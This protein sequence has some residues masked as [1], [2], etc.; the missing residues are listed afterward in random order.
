MN[1]KNNI[2]KPD[3]VI[4]AGGK[5]SRI[6]KYTNYKQKCSAIIN[7]KPF[8]NYLINHVSKYEINR[9]FILVGYKPDKIIRNY[10]NK[11]KNFRKIKCITEKKPLGTG[12]ALYQLKKYKIN[13]FYLLNGDTIL[14]IDLSKLSKKISKNS[15][16][17]MSIIKNYNYKSNKQL[18]K[19]NIK[20]RKVIYSKNQNLMNGGVYYFKKKF[21][22][23]IQNKKIS[24][25]KEILPNLIKK[26][27]IDGKIFKE[28]FFIDIGTPGSFAEAEKKINKFIKKPAVF[29]DRDGVINYDYGYVSKFKDFKIKPGVIKSLKLLIKKKY[30][31]FIITNQA[32]IA[33]NKFSLSDFEK[34]NLQFKEYLSKKKV[35]I[36]DIKFCPHH[37]SG[38]IKKYKKKCKCR[39]PSN[40]MITDTIKEWDIDLNKSLMIGDKI[41]DELC[42]KKS[43]IKFYY[44]KK[45]LLS[46]IKNVI[47]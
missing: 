45:N 18:A 11:I 26:N 40:K 3:V 21:L 15:L 6:S 27:K 42:A 4:L 35:F 24:L 23:K 8:I 33:K 17:I 41:T 32:G 39:K 16:G 1:L 46:L 29:F 36:D 43:G 25:E 31:I 2:E 47:K 22:K 28:S 13:N 14:D 37:P 30:H 34:L 20:N 38:T 44:A 12:G 19:L 10:D 5:G 7:K 9:I